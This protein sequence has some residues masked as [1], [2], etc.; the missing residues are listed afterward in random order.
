MKDLDKSN[1]FLQKCLPHRSQNVNIFWITMFI[2]I[3]LRMSPTSSL[4]MEIVS[5]M[6][7]EFEK[8]WYHLIFGLCFLFHRRSSIHSRDIEIFTPT[9]S[10]LFSHVVHCWEYR[11]KLNDDKSEGFWYHLCKPK[12]KNKLFN[13]LR[14][15]EC[16]IL[17]LDQLTEDYKTEIFVKRICRKCTPENSSRPPFNFGKELKIKPWFLFLNPVSCYGIYLE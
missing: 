5:C 10:S 7:S 6:P 15:K 16:L 1:S 17:K 14:S 12:F 8:T 2:L 4:S 11:I 13:I 9:S 3:Q